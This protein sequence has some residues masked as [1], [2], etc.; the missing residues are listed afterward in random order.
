MQIMFFCTFEIALFSN[1]RALCTQLTKV[2]KIVQ[3]RQAALH[4]L[5]Q[6]IKIKSIFLTIFSNGGQ[7][8]CMY[9][10]DILFSPLCASSIL[11]G[12]FKLWIYV[13]RSIV[14]DR[15]PET[16]I[17]GFESA[18]EKWAEGKLN[19]AFLHFSSNVWHIWWFFKV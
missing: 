4:C 6:R 5:P 3:F 2:R 13:H 16:W 9:Y 14:T 1:F 7:S 8:Y 10:F 19:K 11:M 12:F 15:L 18:M 17:L